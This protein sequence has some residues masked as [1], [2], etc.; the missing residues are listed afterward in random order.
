MLIKIKILIQNIIHNFS[1]N[2]FQYFFFGFNSINRNL[3]KQQPVLL[4]HGDSVTQTGPSLQ[5]SAIS[6]SQVTAGVW[7]AERRIF[8]VQFHP[9]V[10][11]TVNGQQMLYNFVVGICGVPQ[12]YTLDCRKESCIKYIREMVGSS[13]VL[14]MVSGGVDSTVCAALLKSALPA[15]QIHAVHVDN[16]NDPTQSLIL[17]YILILTVFVFLNLGFLRKNE[18][19]EVEESLN[20]MGLK[21]IVKNS[22]Y[23]F[24]KATTTVR[25]ANTTYNTETPMLCF[26]I[27]PEEKRKIIGDTFLKVAN[28]TMKEL[29]LDPS[30]V[31]LAQGT[32][33][34]DLIE[35]ASEMVSKNAETIKTHHNDTEL[36]RQLR[37]AGR[38]VEPLKDFHKDEVRKLGRDLGLP[39]ALVER[40][41]FPGP[42]LAI[43]ILCASEP[44]MEKD[45]SETQ[46]ISQ[47]FKLSKRLHILITNRFVGYCTCHC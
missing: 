34:P 6:S 17:I 14:V 32:L 43:R 42:G 26:A 39:E 19:K 41:P 4:T 25:K 8:G 20:K 10:D 45:F 2:D 38:V 16:G 33:R 7:N 9:E 5:M 29:N 44:Y 11:I 36:V 22:F 24:F 12:S 13:K 21:I 15:N 47:S 28:E 3:E 46:V 27:N 30:D 18:S 31:Y 37:A 40:H 1:A 23:K 35:S